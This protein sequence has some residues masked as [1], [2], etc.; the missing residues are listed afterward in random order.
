MKANPS[1]VFVEPI[2][3]FKMTIVSS[4]PAMRLQS[5][6]RAA[7]GATISLLQNDHFSPLRPLLTLCTEN[8]Q[9]IA[10]TATSGGIRSPLLYPQHEQN[11]LVCSSPYT[12]TSPR[13]GGHAQQLGLWSDPS[14][15]LS[16]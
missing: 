10:A 16:H 1:F 2:D 11:N 8:N 13:Q 7:F 5:I 9:W 14:M 12:T 4:N 3:N 6:Y 15:I